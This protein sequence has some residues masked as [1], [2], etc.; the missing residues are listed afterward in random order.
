MLRKPVCR[1]VRR[2]L[3]RAGFLKQMGRAGNQGEFLFAVHQR[4]S[5]LVQFDHTVVCT[6]GWGA[7][8][9]QCS[10]PGEIR[11]AAARYHG[12]DCQINVNKPRE[13]FFV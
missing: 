2:L 12:G 13:R 5:L 4:V 6:A 3:Q 9:A 10:F 7:Y 11:A 8:A 1:A